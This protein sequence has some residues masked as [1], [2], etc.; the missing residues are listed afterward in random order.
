MWLDWLEVYKG[1]FQDVQDIQILEKDVCERP[2]FV[3]PEEYI[4]I[5]IDLPMP[6][7]LML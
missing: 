1:V 2:S 4:S 6:L 5:S 7:L 3:S